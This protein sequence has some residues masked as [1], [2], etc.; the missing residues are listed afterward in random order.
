MPRLDSSWNTTSV[1]ISD[2]WHLTVG[3]PEQV[4]THSGSVALY[5]VYTQQAMSGGTT[6]TAAVNQ[7][8]LGRQTQI[9][10]I[11]V[12]DNIQAE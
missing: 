8:Q 9:N 6:T 1:Q 7:L 2:I 12:G 5:H 11:I 10:K 3:R 4:R